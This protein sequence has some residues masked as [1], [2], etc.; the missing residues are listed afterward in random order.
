MCPIHPQGSVLGPILHR[1]CNDTSV[2][3]GLSRHFRGV[4][5]HSQVGLEDQLVRGR[6]FQIR[7]RS[8]HRI[9]GLLLPSKRLQSVL[10]GPLVGPRVTY[11]L[12][13]SRAGHEHVVSRAFRAGYGLV[14]RLVYR[15]LVFKVLRC[16]TGFLTLLPITS[17][18][19]V[20]PVVASFPKATTGED[21]VQL[22]LTGR[23]ALTATALATRR[24]GNALLRVR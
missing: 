15:S 11:R 8:H 4:E 17:F 1:G 13:R 6:G 20:P 9:W 23:H 21:R 16:V 5:D 18:L 24:V 19:R 7:D 22:R 2:P 10:V 12:Y 14:P 3:I